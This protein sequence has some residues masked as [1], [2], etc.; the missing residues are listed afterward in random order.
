MSVEE[1][2]EEIGFIVKRAEEEMQKRQEKANKFFTKFFIS[3]F[4]VNKSMSSQPALS[5]ARLRDVYIHKYLVDILCVH[6]SHSKV[7]PWMHLNFTNPFFLTF[8]SIP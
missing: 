3:V 5:D 7:K 8:L 4:I 2:E 1:A 6:L